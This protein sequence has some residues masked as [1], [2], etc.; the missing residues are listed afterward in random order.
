MKLGKLAV[1]LGQLAVLFILGYYLVYRN[2]ILN[3]HSLADHDW[4]V[5]WLPFLGSLLAVAAA[6]TFN[7]QVWRMMVLALSGVR[8]GAFRAA[9]IWF[10]S[11]LGRYLPGKVWQIAGMAMLA[12]REGV[13]AVD[14]AAAAVLNQ[15]LH[16]LAGTAVG[17][18][19]LPAELAAVL[20]PSAKW[21]WLAL[22]PVLV[23]LYPPLLNRILALASRIA[24]K[25]AVACGMRLRDLLLWFCLNLAVWLVYGACFYYFTISVVPGAGISMGTAVGAYAVGYVVGFLVLFAPGGLGVRELLIAGILAGGMGEARATVAALAARIWVTLAELV[26][27]TVLLALGGLPGREKDTTNVE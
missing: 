4:N 16:L 20:G 21:A 1:R 25:P 13:S 18:A 7:A 22:P 6:F 15:V 23:M 27:L 26:P 5:R 9:Y 17:L 24:G 8:V 2:L 14:S 3:W 10:V 12:R 19:F 11:N